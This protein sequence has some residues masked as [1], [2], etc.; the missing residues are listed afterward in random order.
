MDK[1]SIAP[2]MLW[3]L[4]IMLLV[5]ALLF[6]INVFMRTRNDVLV[7]QQERGIQSRAR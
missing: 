6:I 5:Y 1:P 3:P 4:L 7:L 2:S